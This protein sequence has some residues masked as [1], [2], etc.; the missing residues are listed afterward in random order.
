MNYLPFVRKELT[1]YLWAQYQNQV[2]HAFLISQLLTKENKSPL[3]LDHYAII[4]L[5]S[6]KTGLGTLCHIFSAIGYIVQ[7]RDYLEDKQNEFLWLTEMDAIEKPPEKVLPQVVVADFWLEEMPEKIRKIIKKYANEVKHDYLPEIQNLS[8]KAYLGQEKAAYILINLLKKYFERDRTLPT[9]RDFEEVREYN[10][11]LAWVLVFGRQPNH[12][13]FGIHL[14]EKFNSLE[15]FNTFIKEEL[16]IALNDSE[17]VI[18][19]NKAQGIEQSS[20]KGDLT[21]FYVRDGYIYLPDRFMEFV[22]RYPKEGH[23]DPQKWNHYFTGF[24][25]KNANKVIESVYQD[26]SNLT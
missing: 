6:P 16:N 25:A 8:G 11:L 2:K 3:I 4:D 15:S 19:G 17:G 5:P 26:K 12:F 10:E 21:K 22:W 20:T 13:S 24:V 23:K 18:K 14:L 1:Q 9:V 7:G